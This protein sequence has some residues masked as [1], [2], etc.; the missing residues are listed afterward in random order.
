MAQHRLIRHFVIGDAITLYRRYPGQTDTNPV[1][2]AAFSIQLTPTSTPILSKTVT[3]TP[4][5]DGEVTLDGSLDPFVAEVIFKLSSVDTALLS[6]AKNYL[7]KI[8]L[9]LQDNNTHTVE[10]GSIRGEASFSSGTFTAKTT[11]A[12]ASM[13]VGGRTANIIDSWL[14]AIL[15]DFR[16]LKVWDEHARRTG[17]D[18]LTFKLAY[19]NLNPA[20]SL[21]L[22]DGNNNRIFLTNLHLNYA[23][24]SFYVS[25]D[26]GNQDYFLTYQFNLFPEQDLTAFLEQTLQ[27][28]NIS[29]E[30]GSYLTGYR[31]IEEA[32]A[33]WDGILAIGAAA[34]A[35]RRLA[36]N[37]ALWRNSLIF[38]DGTA[39]QQIVADAATQYST[40]FES[41]R[42]S[43]KRGQFLAPPS[44]YYELFRNSGFGFLNPSGKY[45]GLQINRMASY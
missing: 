33:S 19:E 3:I 28:I 22:N 26:D 45:R 34:K 44:Q 31:T 4:T 32:P 8:V 11:T 13:F 25:E 42:L 18:P 23:D 1:V 36:T 43:V 21:E 35:F 5:V 14:D 2:S 15:S 24:G 39:G 29:S 16:Q 10:G 17:E 12:P 9:T 37:S 27:E 30:A 6:P 40:F 41:T 7:Y 38:R 20:G